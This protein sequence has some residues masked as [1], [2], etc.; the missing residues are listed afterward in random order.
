MQ[1]IIVFYGGKSVEHDI[2]I[3]TALQVMKNLDLK[4]Y[5]IFPIYISE[6]NDW[7]I[8]DNYLD[9]NIYAERQYKGKKIVN[10]FFDKYLINKT[11][12]GFKKNQKIDIAINCM[13]GLN[14]ED[15][16]LSGL[17]ELNNFPYVGSGIIASGIG[18]D[19]VLQ[20]DI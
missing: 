17:L 11:K 8:L 6:N 9:L 12:F 10:G 19:K 13:H 5:K 14:G 3:L 16:T 18:M 15:G 7:F 4:K 2:S 20:K 1:N